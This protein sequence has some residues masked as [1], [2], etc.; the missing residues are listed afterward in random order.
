MHVLKRIVLYTRYATDQ[1][2]LAWI[3]TQPDLG[4]QF[5]P[6]QGWHLAETFVDAYVS[7][8]SFETRSGLQA[9]LAVAKTGAYSVF[10]C[11]TLDRLSRDVEHSA[12]ILKILQ[13]HDVDLW[14]V[15]GA[16][17]VSSMEL[18]LRAVLRQ[19]V[20]EQVRYRVRA[21]RPLPNMGGCQAV[22]F[23]ATECDVSSMIVGSRF[24]ACV[25]LTF[26]MSRSSMTPASSFFSRLISSASSLP[27]RSTKQTL[28][29]FVK[30]MLT[31]AE[32]LRNLRNRIASLCDLTHR[33]TLKLF[34]EI[35]F[36]HGLGKKVSANLGLFAVSSSVGRRCQRPNVEPVSPA[37][38]ARVRLVAW[39][40]P[41]PAW[42]RPL[43]SSP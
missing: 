9:A 18:G 35:R 5:V 37:G 33:V 23:T 11:L 14:K 26:R 27:W 24:A 13:F 30:R 29:P 8:S 40:I 2:D 10:L 6:Q 1:Q 31:D 15:H 32:P 20:L 34:A 17:A 21:G 43:R 3:E 12:Q 16:A 39:K 41:L 36:A 25:R 22:S 42:F 7:G 4:K 28:L 38:P 19:E